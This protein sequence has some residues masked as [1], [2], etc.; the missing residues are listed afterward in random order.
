[1]A[2]KHKNVHQYIHTPIV[3]PKNE[4]QTTY[5]IT[6]NNNDKQKV[7]PMTP[8][9]ANGNGLVCTSPYLK[10]SLMY[11]KLQRNIVLRTK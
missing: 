5:Y 9:Y 6:I 10:Y 3:I 8:H 7:R 1:M 2:R 11:D 4:R